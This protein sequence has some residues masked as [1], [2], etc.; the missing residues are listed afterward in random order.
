MSNP[1][2]GAGRLA[3]GRRSGAGGDRARPAHRRQDRSASATT[4]RRSPRTTRTSRTARSARA[5]QRARQGLRGARREVPGRRRGADLLRALH[6]R[7]AVAGGPDLRRVPQG[8]GDP[9]EAVRE[10]SRPSGRR[11]LPDPQLRR[12]ADRAARA[13]PPR[14]ATPSIAP[15]APHALHMPSHIFTRVGAWEDSVATNRRSADVGDEGQASPTRRTTRATTRCT[16][17]CSSARDG[18]ARTR[19]R[20]GA[21][22]HGLQPG[23][24][25]RPVRGRRDA[26]ALRARARRL[27]RGG[28]A[29]AAAEQVPVH[30][31]DHALRARARRGA[32]RR[33]RRGARRTSSSSPRCTSS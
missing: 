24:L 5:R 6:R 3:E 12:A 1:L 19:D 20:R 22:G 13:C 7:H 30:R 18:E 17:T 27:A 15:D 14:A 32:Q 21:A 26:G 33:R 16:P 28:A 31:G 8:G 4:S 2:A 10:V 11:A 25:R 29:A 23:R 9:R